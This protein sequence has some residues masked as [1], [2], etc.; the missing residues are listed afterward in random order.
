MSATPAATNDRNVAG[1]TVGA[2][3]A[4]TGTFVCL[5][6]MVLAAT[7]WAIWEGRRSAIREYEG[8]E[9]RL[10]T[11]LADQAR[12]T[13]A[14]ADM[15]VAAT[16]DQI[17]ASGIET[18]DDLRRTMSNEQVN[19]ELGQKLRNLPQLE[20]LTIQDSDGR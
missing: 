11:V 4:L 2:T 8:R 15:V 10:G 14:A 20:A 1:Q 5:I 3:R 17:Q 6:L 13:L 7:A 16:V 18:G 12:R 9:V 19:T